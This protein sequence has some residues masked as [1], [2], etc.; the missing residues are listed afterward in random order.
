MIGLALVAVVAAAIVGTTGLV[1]NPVVSTT[2]G[3]DSFDH[4]AIRRLPGPLLPHFQIL[5]H[6]RPVR[7]LRAL[8]ERERFDSQVRNFLLHGHIGDPPLAPAEGR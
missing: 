2:P 4:I 7:E 6:A 8:L 3:E 5:C 1:Q